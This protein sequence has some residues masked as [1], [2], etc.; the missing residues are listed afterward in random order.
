MLRTQWN[1]NIEGFTLQAILGNPW[2]STG[3]SNQTAYFNSLTTDIPQG[4]TATI[5][6]WF[7]FPKRLNQYLKSSA[8]PA[9]PYNYTESQILELADTGAIDG[10]QPAFQEIPTKLCPQ[11]DWLSGK[12]VYGPYGPR[13]WMDEYCEWS[14]VRNSDYKI[15]RI[16]FTCEN[17]EYWNSV[18]MVSP[19]RVAELYASTLNWQAPA[20][21]QVTV[22]V[23]DLY[24]KDASGNPV[25]DP[26]TGR[27]AYNPLNR[28]NS[29]PIAV[30]GLTTGQNTGG[31]MHLTSTPNTIQTE[32]ALAGGATVQRTIGNNVPQALICC[33]QYG[34]EYR[35][36]DPHIGQRTNQVVANG[37]RV[38][39][40]NPTGLYIQQ[41]TLDVKNGG[42]FKLPA[43][44]NLPKSATVDD[45]WQIVRG[46]QTLTDPVTGMLYGLPDPGGNFI[47]HAVFQLPRAWVDAG[48][49]FTIGDIHQAASPKK[50]IQWGG[51]I[52]QPMSIGLW[53]RP[54]AAPV[55]AAEACVAARVPSLAQ[56]LQMFHAAIWDAFYNT[57]VGNP[58]GMPMSLASNSTMIAPIIPPGAQNVPMVLSCSA[59]QPGPNGEPPQVTFPGGN[60]RDVTASAVTL[61]PNTASYA[62]PGN[63]YPGSVQLLKFNVSV[64][65]TAV[66]GLRSVQLTNHGDMSADPIPAF[67]NIKPVG[68]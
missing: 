22:N 57:S 66:T 5:I 55:P 20:A 68:S 19:D 47:L 33:S 61:E 12:Q 10:Q 16:D 34:Q 18:W 2:T 21:Q 32:M 46:N 1:T 26:S 37:N 56:P 9:N 11:A 48:V 52:V 28:W 51:E 45:C 14:V 40:A 24:V 62:V 29:G 39:L 4:S 17:P 38:A 41:P 31:A 7:A 15:T 65:A 64:S 59:V 42:P 8:V 54:I 27:P 60:S 53:A 13:G 63:S 49:S 6:H 67:L 23:A 58:M 50:T 43:D 44:P 35:N 3:A 30:R 25:V 36:S